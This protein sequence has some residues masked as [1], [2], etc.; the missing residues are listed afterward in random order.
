MFTNQKAF[1]YRVNLTGKEDK[2][3]IE[4]RGPFV[5]IVVSG[6]GIQMNTGN[7][8]DII[9]TGKCVYVAPKT[10]CSFQNLGDGE[11]SI[12]VFELK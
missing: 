5:A 7:K 10:K 3:Q 9:T 8:T 12:T 1:A 6:G 4:G 2:K 11:T